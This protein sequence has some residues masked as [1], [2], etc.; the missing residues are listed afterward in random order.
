M[1]SSCW[2]GQ[3]EGV[4]KAILI[5]PYLRT[6]GAPGIRPDTRCVSKARLLSQDLLLIWQVTTSA[7]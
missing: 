5:V 3:K 2:G 7:S 4:M 6:F 1:N